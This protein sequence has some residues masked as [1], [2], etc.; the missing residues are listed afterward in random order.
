MRGACE[1]LS[2]FWMGLQGNVGDVDFPSLGNGLDG[3]MEQLS[4]PSGRKKHIYDREA[5]G[6]HS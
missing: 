5:C 6:N 3:I 1:S 4:N 2:L